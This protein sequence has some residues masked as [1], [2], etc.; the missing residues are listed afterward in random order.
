MHAYLHTCIHK[1]LTSDALQV[2]HLFYLTNK[3]SR[4]LPTCRRYC[5]LVGNWYTLS[6]LSRIEESRLIEWLSD[7]LIT[8]F[9]GG[10]PV[11]SRPFSLSI[12]L[13]SLWL[14]IYYLYYYYYPSTTRLLT[15]C[16]LGTYTYLSIYIIYPTC[17]HTHTYLPSTCSSNLFD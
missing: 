8:C 10:Y 6:P 11:A 9:H 14:P 3:K 16:H 7:W 5:R 13:P 1:Y 4:Y 2:G 17:R 12:L 15:Y